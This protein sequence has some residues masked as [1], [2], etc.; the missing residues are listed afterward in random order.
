LRL[1]VEE[2]ETM[3]ERKGV[4][5]DVDRRSVDAGRV[6]GRRRADHGGTGGDAR[7]VAGGLDGGRQPG[8]AEVGGR[9]IAEA[10]VVPDRDHDAG[11]EVV[12]DRL[13]LVAPHAEVL[14]ALIDEPGG[15]VIDVGG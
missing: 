1:L 6:G 12:E 14:G 13:E 10:A 15:G 11:V 7:P 4:P 2:L 9:R 3:V 5:L 8:V